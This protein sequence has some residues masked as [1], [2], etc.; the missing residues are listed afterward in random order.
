MDEITL[1][2]R[3]KYEITSVSKFFHEENNLQIQKITNNCIWFD[4]NT[5]DNILKCSIYMQKKTKQ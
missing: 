4:T 2:E 3:N 5:P 1:S